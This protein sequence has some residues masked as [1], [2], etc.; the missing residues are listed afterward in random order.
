[1]M[2]VNIKAPRG[3][4]YETAEQAI[5]HLWIFGVYPKDW[6]ELHFGRDI[7][8]I[9]KASDAMKAKDYSAFM[10]SPRRGYWRVELAA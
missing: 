10:A 9:R 2:H 1:M 7:A 6:T 3:Q 8:L 5:Q 4:A